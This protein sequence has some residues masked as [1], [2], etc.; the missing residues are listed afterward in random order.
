MKVLLVDDDEDIRRLVSLV[1]QK[2]SGMSVIPASHGLEGVQKALEEN[3]D[4]ILLDVM[5]PEMD[6]PAVLVELRKDPATARIPVIFLTAKVLAS[7]LARLKS[8]DTAGVI[9]K[10]FEALTLASHIRA[11]LEE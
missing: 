9:I 11:L 2:T 7:E 3:P 5:M 1:L 8:L 10:P 4:V 6:G